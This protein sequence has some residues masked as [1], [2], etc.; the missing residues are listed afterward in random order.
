MTRRFLVPIGLLSLASDP[1]GTFVGET[2]FNTALGKIRVYDGADWQD[3]AAGVQ[4]TTGTDGNDGAQGATGLQGTQGIQGLQ[5]TASVSESYVTTAIANN[6][7]ISYA[8]SSSGTT[9]TIAGSDISLIKEFTSSSSITVT[10]PNDAS[11]TEF[12][13]G[14]SLELRQM[15]TGRITVAVTSPA[16]MV[17]TDS[18]TKTR[19]QYSSVVLE[20]R[21]SN[22][23]I[24]TGDIDA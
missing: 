19:T 10:I 14:S 24:L 16:T 4:G 17:S 12:P 8:T 15:G 18:Y 13:I 20:K 5:G 21:A 1:T 2:Y 7:L 23:W 22:S 3:A 9:Y 11:D 6:N